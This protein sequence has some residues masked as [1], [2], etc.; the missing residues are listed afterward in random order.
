MGRGFYSPARTGVYMSLLLRPET[1]SAQLPIITVAAAAAVCEAIE[2]L[3]GLETKVK[4]VNDVLVCGR[5]VCGIL[6]E[7]GQ[8]L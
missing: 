4:W 3:T 7:G 2:A 5:K 6:T 8:R 1:D